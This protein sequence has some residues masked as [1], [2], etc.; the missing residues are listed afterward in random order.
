MRHGDVSLVNF[1]KRKAD[2]LHLIERINTEQTK[3]ALCI[4]G[5]HLL[6]NG[7]TQLLLS[8]SSG[9]YVCTFLITLR[10]LQRRSLGFT[11]DESCEAALLIDVCRI[12]SSCNSNDMVVL[13]NGGHHYVRLSIEVIHRFSEHF[14]CTM[15]R[16][17][18]VTQRLASITVGSGIAKANVLQQFCCFSQN[19]LRRTRFSHLIGSSDSFHRSSLATKLV[20]KGTL[21]NSQRVSTRSSNLIER[22]GANTL[23]HSNISQSDGISCL[24]GQSHLALISQTYR[25]V[26]S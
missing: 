18:Q 19:N 9:Q 11:F 3:Y 7:D 20:G 17:N 13:I 24:I 21:S 6:A 4:L 14:V 10:Q 16:L 8:I 25:S 15:L 12:L 5:V 26:S 1:R 2:S 22:D 23:L